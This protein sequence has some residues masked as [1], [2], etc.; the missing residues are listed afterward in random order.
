MNFP[1]EASP[2]H[3]RL[4]GLDPGTDTLGS[5]IIDVDLETYEPTIVFGETHHASKAAKHNTWKAEIRSG[6]DARLDCHS[7]YLYDLYSCTDP[8]LVAA[9]SPFLN[10]KMVTSF[11]ALVE[12]YAMLRETLWHYSPSMY[13]RR[14]DPITAKNY[15]GVS[16]IKTD[17][18]DM[19]RAVIALYKDKCAPG[20]DIESFD[21]HTIDAVAVTHCLL[22]KYLMNVEIASTKKKKNR[23]KGRRGTRKGKTK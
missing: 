1:E 23:R 3:I 6:R 16:H 11:E 18:T 13:L 5:A 4:L 22:Q 10:R 21:E 9:E 14:I 7:R 19:R 15:V 12:C 2:N 20:V 8:V 17:K